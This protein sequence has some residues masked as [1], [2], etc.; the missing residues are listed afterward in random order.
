MATPTMVETLRREFPTVPGGGTRALHLL[1]AAAA[2]AAWRSALTL[3]RWLRITPRTP[4]TVAVPPAAGPRRPGIAAVI[5]TCNGEALIGTALA[6]ARAQQPDEIIVVDNGSRDNTVATARAACPEVRMLSLPGNYG[7]VAAANAGLRATDREQILLLNDDIE[8][9]AG[10]VAALRAALDRSPRCGS[11]A[12]L[13]LDWPDGERLQA[14]GDELGFGFMPRARLAGLP[15]GTAGV[16]ENAVWGASAAAVLY[17]GAMLDAIGLF[18]ERLIMTYEDVDLAWRAVN[19]GWE[20][21]LVPAAGAI[22]RRLATI[23]QSSPMHAYFTVKNRFAPAAR[24]LQRRRLREG[25]PAVWVAHT[26][27]LAGFLARPG[28]RAAAR[29]GWRHGMR[30]LE[31]WYGSRE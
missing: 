16:E 4:D 7:F 25:L 13:L 1:P 9:Q 11:A 24:N 15:R 19:A 5:I 31:E 27:L 6:S 18:D 14:A 20:C 22:H 29:A 8:L 2:E 26:R 17:R 12:P 10:C 21:R 28:C 23:G 30:D 3:W